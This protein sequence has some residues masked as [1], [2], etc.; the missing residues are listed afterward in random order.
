MKL[1]VIYTRDEAALICDM[2]ERILEKYEIFIPSPEDDERDEGDYG[3]YGST[4]SDLLDGIE[5]HIISVLNRHATALV[6]ER[7]F[8]GVV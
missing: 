6:M 3:L 5:E 8:S 2:F 1:D 4:Y 7:E